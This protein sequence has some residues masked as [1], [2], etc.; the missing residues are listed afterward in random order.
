M[1]S[2]RLHVAAQQPIPVDQPAATDPPADPAGQTRPSPPVVDPPRP[3][4]WI[5]RCLDR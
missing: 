1:L 3:V 2:H 5:G 4:R